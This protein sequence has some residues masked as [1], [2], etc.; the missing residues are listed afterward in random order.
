MEYLTPED[1]E[2]AAKNGIPEVRVKNRFYYLY[3]SK[4]RSITQPCKSPKGLW[5]KYKDICAETGISESQFY[6]RMREYGMT[7]DE[8]A[9]TKHMERGTIK[10][11]KIKVTKEVQEIAL[12]NGISIPTLKY[13]VNYLKWAVERA[14]T[15]PIHERKRRGKKK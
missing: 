9:T 3:W 15:E 13:R 2:I 11:V 6:K 5:P 1:F 7:P 4:E 10:K 14:S 12:Q 8:A